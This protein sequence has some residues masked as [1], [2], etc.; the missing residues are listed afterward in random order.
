MNWTDEFEHNGAESIAQIILQMDALGCD[1]DLV[2][3]AI[4]RATAMALGAA[5]GPEVTAQ[6]LRA[7]ADVLEQDA[8]RPH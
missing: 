3:G 4:V 7:A 5:C 8:S 2:V 1:R 6:L